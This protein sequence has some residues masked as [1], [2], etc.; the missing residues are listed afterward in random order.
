MVAEPAIR[1]PAGDRDQRDPDKEMMEVVAEEDD[2]ASDREF[3]IGSQSHLGRLG[4]I[5]VGGAGD[6]NHDPDG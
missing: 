5:G 6:I 4:K 2:V 1:Q 3:R